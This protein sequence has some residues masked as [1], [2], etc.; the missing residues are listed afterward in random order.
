[1]RDPIVK[2]L[3]EMLAES[4]APEM[5]EALLVISRYYKRLF[6]REH[7]REYIGWAVVEAALAKALAA[8]DGCDP[9][10]TGA[11]HSH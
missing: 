11:A 2:Q 5:V 4:S 9:R 7:N 1:M 3:H 10:A 8:M 6:K